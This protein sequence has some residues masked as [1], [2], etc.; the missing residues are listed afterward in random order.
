MHPVASVIQQRGTSPHTVFVFPS[1]I[2]SRLWLE[3]AL[4]IL[5]EQSLPADRF[6]AWDR[7]KECAIQPMVAGK[8]PVSGRLRKLYAISLAKRNAESDPPFFTELIPQPYAKTGSIFASWISSLLPSLA[9]W[10]QRTGRPDHFDREACDLALLKKD[11]TTFLE[12]R[13]LFEPAWQKPPLKDT[14]KHYILFFP[15]AIE[16]FR[17]YRDLVDSA[18]F[19]ETITVDQALSFMP[20]RDKPKSSRFGTTREELRTLA[21]EIE[22]LLTAGVSPES[23]A[24]SVPE[25][26]AVLPY[27][28][29][30]LNLRG[31]PFD[32]RSGAQL[33]SHPAGRLFP[34]IRE[35]ASTGFSFASVKAL[36]LDRLV[37]WKERTMAERLVSFGIENHCLT[38]WSEDG[39]TIDVWMEAF[40]GSCSTSTTELKAWYT[41]LRKHISAMTG[42]A[43]FSELRKHYFMFRNTFLDMELLDP[44]EDAVLGRCLDELANL[45]ALEDLYPEIIPDNP[46]NFFISVLEDTIYVHQ[47]THG[48]I[49]LFPYRVAAGTPFPHHFILDASQDH[50]TIVYR[51]LSFLRHDNRL[52]LGLADTDASAAFFGMYRLSGSRFSV[53]DHTFS[54]YCTAHGYFDTYRSADRITDDPF[55]Q[56]AAFFADPAQLPAHRYPIQ[57]DGFEQWQQRR[58][59][60]RFS[61]LADPFTGIPDTLSRQVEDRTIREGAVVINQ[62]ELSRFAYCNARWFLGKIL[63]LKKQD[64]DAA[65]INE[66][67]MGLIIHQALHEVYVRIRDEDKQFFAAHREQY[68]QWADEAARNTTA[69]SAEFKGPIAGPIISLLSRR[70]SDAIRLVIDLDARI[71]D[72]F[73]PVMLEDWIELRRGDKLFTGKI[74]RISQNPADMNLVLIDYKSG[75]VKKPG[76]YTPQPEGAVVEEQELGDYQMPMYLFLAESTLRTTT[77]DATIQDAWFASIKDKK[78]VPIVKGES[79]G[80]QTSGRNAVPREK[81]DPALQVFLNTADRFARAVREQ[82]FT[83]PENLPRKSCAECEYFRICRTTYIAEDQ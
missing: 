9:L 17:E 11:Y 28:S 67:N 82:N 1:E 56:E 20:E 19:M 18:N 50:A 10:E 39:K 76:D 46:W 30:E 48:G 55:R 21:L 34:L 16:D 58:N 71:L 13:R 29:R 69:Q 79:W 32:L 31:I 33:T 3:E 51:E 42:A 12:T 81:F 7:F 2:A 73:A 22:D 40:A 5:G 15:E 65:M 6:I 38:S 8:Q 75:N 14:G 57:A 35:C 74:D 36:M 24:V 52:K 61:F 54:G 27:L 47:R 77:P 49:A 43:T 4:D 63:G 60:K 66:R 83:R 59:R 68:Y 41:Q 44:A 70:V 37:P 45:T 64:R 53:S 26:D 23:V 25:L 62:T 72:S 80:T 78:Y